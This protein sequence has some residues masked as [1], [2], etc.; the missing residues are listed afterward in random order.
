[1]IYFILSIFIDSVTF[2]CDNRI[3]NEA[4]LLL[5]TFGSGS[6]EYSNHTPD[7]F[8]FSAAHQQIFAPPISNGEFGFMNKIPDSYNTWHGGALDHTK[9]DC[10]GYMY[11]V[12]M[13]ADNNQVLFNSTVNNL[14][15]EQRYKLFAYFANAERKYSG[16][17]VEPN[18]RFEIRT[19]YTD[20][21]LLAQFNTSNIPRSDAMTWWKCGVSFVT[22]TSS[23]VLLIFS[24]VG[25]TTGNDLV[26]DD[27]ELRVSSI[28]CPNFCSPGQYT[29]YC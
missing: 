17:P 28:V 4:S 16:N 5:I 6:Q 27:I 20:N 8:Q 22:N 24:N 11:L 26:I 19:P 3:T 2:C 13:N 9:N 10:G 14:S 29:C 23:V 15:I 25:G 18:V 1:M 7:D 12:C 21:R